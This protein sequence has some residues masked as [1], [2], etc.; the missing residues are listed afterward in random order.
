MTIYVIKAL[1]WFID[2]YRSASFYAWDM[3]MDR[4]ERAG[5][6]TEDAA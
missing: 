3:R 2:V 4:A 6:T 5:Q 1:A